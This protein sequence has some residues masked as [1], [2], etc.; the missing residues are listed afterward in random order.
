[1]TIPRSRRFPHGAA[2]RVRR[3]MRVLALLLVAGACVIPAAA[4][5]SQALVDVRHLH[6]RWMDNSG[7]RVAFAYRCPGGYG[8][9]PVGPPGTELLVSQFQPS[10]VYSQKTYRSDVVCDGTTRRVVRNVRPPA[11]ERFLPAYLLHVDV[12]LNVR[13]PSAPYPGILSGREFDTVSI[14][15]S[16]TAT[17]AADMR[18]GQVR[19]S[20]SGRRIVVGVS[21]H[22]PNGWFVDV[23]DDVDWADI[24]GGQ[25][26][27]GASDVGFWA[28]LG[29][30]VVCDGT[31]HTIVKRINP[32][33]GARW[34]PSL[35][36]ELQA[37]MILRNAGASDS[38]WSY[39]GRTQLISG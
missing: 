7:V 21:Y 30:D 3:P 23:Q 36:V 10:E 37:K 2:A 14:S 17:L 20:Q 12:D 16:G 11:G 9:R 5:A 4:Q 6:V 13:S 24:S 34:S 18:L 25:D 33:G 32:Q 19:A 31:E 29:D 27:T 22:C 28:P 1:M 8:Y 39:E 26:R 15:S 35:P 38:I